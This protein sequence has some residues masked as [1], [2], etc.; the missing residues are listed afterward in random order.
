MNTIV[1]KNLLLYPPVEGSRQAHEAW[2]Q[3]IRILDDGQFSDEFHALLI[4][5]GFISKTCADLAREHAK[6]YID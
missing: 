6:K 4:A 3:S 2:K 1:L 5:P